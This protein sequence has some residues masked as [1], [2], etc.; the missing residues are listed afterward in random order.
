MAL[1]KANGGLMSA[2]RATDVTGSVVKGIR[3]KSGFPRTGPWR[4]ST[5]LSIA[6][7]SP[8]GLSGDRGRPTSGPF[9]EPASPRATLLEVVTPA[10]VGVRL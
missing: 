6:S 10:E 1:Y 9:L 7:H 4:M 5:D 8:Q 2:I 3:R